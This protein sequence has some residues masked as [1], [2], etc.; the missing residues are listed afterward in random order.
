MTAINH[1]ATALLI[2]KRWRGLPVLG[3]AVLLLAAGCMPGASPRE[4][5]SIPSVTVTQTGKGYLFMEGRDSV[6]LYRDR[7]PDPEREHA[8]AHYIHPLYG[9]NGEILT[10]D[11]P[12]DHPHQHGIFWAWHQMHVGERSVGDGWTQDDIS[13]NVREVDLLEGAIYSPRSSVA[14]FRSL[15]SS[16]L[17]ARIQW[18]SPRY[19]DAGG[20]PEPFVEET[21]TI[22][23][24][25]GTGDHRAVDVTIELR[26]L[27]DSVRIGGSED[28]KG[29]GGFSARIRLPEDVQFVGPGG[30][31]QP[32]VTD[33]DAG[34]WLDFS[35]TF[36]GGRP[37]GVA[38]LQHPSNPGFPQPWILRREDSMQNPK[39]P[40]AEP[41]LLPK[42]E[43]ITL[44]YRLIVHDGRADAIP[45]ERLH[46][47]YAAGR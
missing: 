44:R 12:E 22:H 20:E 26:A 39:W 25:P 16:G 34:P 33:V 8:R 47:R 42:G 17:Q 9:I 6:L 36:G 32:L 15:V 5:R 40:G 28:E 21:T 18:I 1:A 37:S 24:S 2:N 45:L 3:L 31:V 4:N 30:P 41:V 10:E 46:A 43:P 14:S 27:V 23:V 19:L 7:P 35:A 13:W 29:Y 38:I 11:A